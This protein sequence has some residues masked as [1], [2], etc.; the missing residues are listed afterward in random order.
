MPILQQRGNVL[1]LL[2][3]N[4]AQPVVRV[5]IGENGT[6][7]AFKGD[8]KGIVHAADIHERKDAALEF[9]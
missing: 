3:H 9:L 7:S 8:V 1:L 5:A 4:P 2:R 6:V